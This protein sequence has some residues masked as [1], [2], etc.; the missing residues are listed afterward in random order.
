MEVMLASVGC[1]VSVMLLLL[2]I[3]LVW[4]RVPVKRWCVTVWVGERV[5]ER[6]EVSS[7]FAGH[8]EKLA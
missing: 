4:A 8:V 6:R 5:Y 7:R 2:A 1:G 3:V